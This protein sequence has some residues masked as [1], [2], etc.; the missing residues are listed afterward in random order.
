MIAYC[1]RTECFAISNIYLH[2]HKHICFYLWYYHYL[3]HHTVV[4]NRKFKIS[5]SSLHARYVRTWPRLS[6]KT[7]HDR[8]KSFRGESLLQLSKRDTKCGYIDST[9]TIKNVE[10]SRGFSF[11]CGK[12]NVRLFVTRNLKAYYFLIHFWRLRTKT[13]C[14]GINGQFLSKKIWKSKII[15]LFQPKHLAILSQLWLSYFD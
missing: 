9:F 2:L 13:H 14:N 3:S 15:L 1:T 5:H 12:S 4:I 8:K 11:V 7:K 6:I 10:I